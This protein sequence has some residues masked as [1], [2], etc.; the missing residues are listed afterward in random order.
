M[1]ELTIM[2]LTVVAGL[3]VAY[4]KPNHQD[5]DLDQMVEYLEMMEVQ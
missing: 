5:M 2:T 4:K 3:F 1:I